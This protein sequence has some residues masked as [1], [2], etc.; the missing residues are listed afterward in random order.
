MSRGK[1]P[2]IPTVTA[3]CKH[4]HAAKPNMTLFGFKHN[5]FCYQTFEVCQPVMQ[6]FVLKSVTNYETCLLI[7]QS[8]FQIHCLLRESSWNGL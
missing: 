3:T 5:M 4:G 2:V 1:G 7:N 6:T 8:K